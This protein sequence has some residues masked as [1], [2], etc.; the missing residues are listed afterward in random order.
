MLL[1]FVRDQLIP[2]IFE[3]KTTNDMHDALVGLYQRG[4]A[5]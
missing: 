2:H 1:D 3:K 5:N 4:N